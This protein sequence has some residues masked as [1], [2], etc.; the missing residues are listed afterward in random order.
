MNPVT[1][2]IKLG[3]SHLSHITKSTIKV[4]ARLFGIKEIRDKEYDSS[5]FSS[6][7]WIFVIG[8]PVGLFIVGT[9]FPILIWMSI[10]FGLLAVVNLD[11]ALMLT[12]IYAEHGHKTNKK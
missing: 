10:V 5:Q 12:A 1:K 4:L 2:F 3:V 9:D 11:E 8:I 7:V 6:A